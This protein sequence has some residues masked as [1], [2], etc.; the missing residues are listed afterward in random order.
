MEYQAYN[1][2]WHNILHRGNDYTPGFEWAEKNFTK[3]FR[4]YYNGQFIECWWQEASGS[5]NLIS[6]YYVSV[7]YRWEVLEDQIYMG[8]EYV[9]FDNDDVIDHVSNG[10]ATVIQAG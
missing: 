1:S 5:W 6:D 9:Y 10:Y 3:E 7:E 4:P 8:N 2:D